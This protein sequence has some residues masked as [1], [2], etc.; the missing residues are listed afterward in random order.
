MKRTLGWRKRRE[1]ENWQWRWNEREC[2]VV[3]E[4]E[5]CQRTC[6][7]FCCCAVYFLRKELVCTIREPHLQNGSTPY[8]GRKYNIRIKAWELFLYLYKN[9]GISVHSIALLLGEQRLFPGYPREQNTRTMAVT[10]RLLVLLMQLIWWDTFCHSVSIC[11][12]L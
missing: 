6:F 7:C 9:Y 11:Y 1:K 12:C 4:V 10:Y 2:E 5:H 3:K 8:E